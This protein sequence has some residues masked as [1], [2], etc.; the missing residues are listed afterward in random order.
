MVCLSFTLVLNLDLGILFAATPSL[1]ERVVEHRLANGLT[2]LMVERHQ[3]PV[4]SINITFAVG[5]INEQVGQTGL[6]HL[7]EHMAFKGTRVV[8]TTDYEK[9]KPML[10]ELS[11]VGTELDQRQRD[12]AA[13]GAGATAE[14]RAAMESLQNRFVELQNRAA[15]Y[16]VG[17]EMALLYQRHGGVGLNA[18]TGKDVT[19]YMISL[20]SNRLPLWAAIEADR[21]A[22]P[23]L[24]E[25]YKERGVVMEE[26]RLRNDDSPNGLLFETFTSAAF[27]AHGYGIPTIGWGSD[28]L[29]L[30]PAATEAFFKAH[31]G[32]DQATIALVGDIN[33]RE[34]IALI[35]RTFGKIPAAP[36]PPPLVTVEPEQR[37]ER[38]VE[39]EF[40]A[41]P[42]IVIGYHK[43]GLG[44]PDDEV[45]DVIDA[46]LS[47]G[48]TSRLHH[49]LV[50]EKRLAASVGSDGNHPGVR[51]PNLFIVTATPLAPHTTTEVEAAI[52]E[53]LERLKQEPVSSTELAKVLNNLDADLV[54]GLR[55]NS[56][57]AS[58]LAL[59]QAVARDWR[60]I[61]KSR[62][63]A[64]A[65][66]AED[67]QRVARQ[68]FTKSNRTV[69]VLVKKAQDK[70]VAANSVGEVKP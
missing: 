27:R 52:Y 32:P 31:Y 51:A 38:R 53:E 1:S 36:L 69:A 45:F 24:R 49:K 46:V 29:S 15:Q 12:L 16:V 59:Y 7:Y 44:H 66:T 54:R 63:K 2:V 5:G 23:V 65:V 35:E 42:A 26:R 30:T 64:A 17:N 56:G 43:P 6:A 68:Y 47:D 37:G 70:T 61:L 57:L 50:R 10:D 14:E 4:V 20:P 39:V 40:D 13:K 58:Q 67:I 55:S 60:Y 22:N 9:E 25:F 48:L 34:T 33:P 21:M 19:R 11:L 3:T 28:I 8:G 62:D 18:S 41:E